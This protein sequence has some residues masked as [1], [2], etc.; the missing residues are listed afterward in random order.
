[1]RP[2]LSNS[3]RK[4]LHK[5]LKQILLSFASNSLVIGVIIIG[6]LTALE[7]H[8]QVSSQTI[9]LIVFIPFAILL[10]I[11]LKIAS[12]Y[13]LDLSNNYKTSSLPIR[14]IEKS[15]NTKDLRNHTSDTDSHLSP[16]LTEYYLHTEQITYWVDQEVFER[17]Q[18]NDELIVH[19]TPK[20]NLILE[21]EKV[22]YCNK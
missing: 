10:L 15:T 5:T 13:I 3:D 17:F 7:N 1:M 19:K 11:I 2:I 4:Q 21:Y 8:L 20:S 14:I 6:I 12:P 16:K 18:V 9:F 22:S